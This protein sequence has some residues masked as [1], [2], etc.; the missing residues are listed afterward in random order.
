MVRAAFRN[1]LWYTDEKA[2]FVSKHPNKQVLTDGLLLKPHITLQLVSVSPTDVSLE[3]FPTA[4]S[5]ALS[6]HRMPGC[7]PRR[8]LVSCSACCRYVIGNNTDFWKRVSHSVD[9]L[10]SQWS[11]LLTEQS[12]QSCLCTAAVAAISWS[13]SSEKCPVLREA[14]QETSLTL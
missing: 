4:C 11:L 5:G 7:I 10:G 8:S 12:K 6:F 1:H 2:N 14:E 13:T 9:K 3:N